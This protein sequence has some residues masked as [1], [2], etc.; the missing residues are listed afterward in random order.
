MATCRSKEAPS[1]PQA[2]L[3]ASDI[4]DAGAVSAFLRARRPKL[5]MHLAAYTNVDGCEANPQL[6]E[7]TNSTGTRNTALACA[8]VDAAML[9]VSTDMY[10][11]ARRPALT[12]RTIRPTR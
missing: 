2:R 8:E 1:L 11:M 4:R 9:Y 7:V 6:A 3:G 5:V 10:L 12:G